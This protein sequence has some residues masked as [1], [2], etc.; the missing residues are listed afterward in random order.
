MHSKHLLS[1]DYIEILCLCQPDNDFAM[2]FPVF[3]RY[4]TRVS[5]NIDFINLLCTKEKCWFKSN[6]GYFSLVSEVH[7]IHIRFGLVFL[8]FVIGLKNTR[9][10]L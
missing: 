9:A 4:A 1:I 6:L 3:I 10:F 8:R 7:A 5:F 2:G